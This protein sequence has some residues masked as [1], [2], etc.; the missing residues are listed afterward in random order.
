MIKKFKKVVILDTV[1]F[2]PEHR[3]ILNSIA[4]EIFEY[5]ASLPE[6]LEKQYEENP[7][8]FLNKKCYT[9]IAI[10]NTPLQ[11]LMDR[12]DGADVIISCWTDIPDEV[13]QSNP[14]LKLI[15]FWTHE[16]EHRINMK[17]AKELGITVEN[18]PDYGT[19]AVAEVTFAGLYQLLQRNFSSNNVTQ[20]N[21]AHAVID[22]IFNYFRK[23]KNNEKYTRS[24]KF[25][26]HFHKI[27]LVKFDFSQKSL[28]KLIPEKLI[29]YKRIG[30]LNIRK[31]ESIMD[32]LRAFN[33]LCEQFEIDDAASAE[34]YK[35]FA[36]ND[37]IFYDSK[38]IDIA[39]IKKMLLMFTDKLVDINTLQSP[40]YS[41]E[42][43]IFGVVGL[44][45][46]G[47]K[48][49]LI[50]KKLGF[51]VVYFSKTR[52]TEI[53]EKYH[54]EYVALEKLAEMSDIV[55]IHVP[56][57][58]AENLFNSE[59]ISKLKRWS[60]FINTADGNAIDQAALTKRMQNGE[61]FAYFDVYPGLPRKDI[62]GL[63]ME[64]NTDW[65]IHDELSNNVIAYRAGWKTQE[66]IRIKTYKL[67]GQMIE[68]IS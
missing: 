40:K 59:L 47:L 33:L 39:K 49:A 7:S 29:A 36:E 16:K 30:L 48:V 3:D 6:A 57:Y 5:P 38:L 50:A 2:Y 55:S 24:G 1:I 53:E 14:Q 46:I 64:N 52:K 22:H 58:K 11:L 68:F 20:N 37:L 4:E 44:G 63:H 8:L 61:I 31:A 9:Q 17:L 13:L 23:I 18:I 25:T 45:R 12:V 21:I 51:K 66:S 10:D 67:L 26:H 15:V 42:D 19:D 43:K 60:I 41:F 32:T 35:F 56:S 54:I 34:Y 65:K 62:L 28:D 27:G